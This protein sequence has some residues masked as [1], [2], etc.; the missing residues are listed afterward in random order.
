VKLLKNQYQ[1]ILNAFQEFG[2][3]SDSFALT[4]RRGRI[5]IQFSS[6]T[7]SFELYRRKLVTLS[8]Q[9]QWHHQEQYELHFHGNHHMVASW[10]D[11]MNQLRGWIALEEGLNKV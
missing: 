10:E 2:M 6:R 11:V 5:I 1:D 9:R 7:S 8:P 4:K 3:D